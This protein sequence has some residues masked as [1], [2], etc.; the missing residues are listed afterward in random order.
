VSLPEQFQPS[1][2]DI[3]RAQQRLQDEEKLA[4]KAFLFVKQLSF[5][6]FRRFFNSKFSESYN[7]ALEERKQAEELVIQPKQVKQIDEQ[8]LKVRTWD[9]ISEL[10][11]QYSEFDLY[12]LMLVV[13]KEMRRAAGIHGESFK[14]YAE[15]KEAILEEVGEVWE[16]YERGDVLH[17]KGE[18]LQAIGT[19][20]K[21]IRTVQ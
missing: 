9:E 21:F 14:D 19:M 11:V 20:I 6:K 2:E 5:D 4:K 10:T 17:A 1:E 7:L 16:A 13:D 12:D 15:A 3:I 18:A 8:F